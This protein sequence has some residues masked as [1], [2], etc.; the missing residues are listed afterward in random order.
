MKYKIT[1]SLSLIKDTEVIL[2]LTLQFSSFSFMWS[3]T[4][5]MQKKSNNFSGVDVDK[6]SFK[7]LMI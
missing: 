2:L 4:E 6:W 1:S 3:K 5:R 7:F